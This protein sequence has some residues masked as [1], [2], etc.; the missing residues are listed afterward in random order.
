VRGFKFFQSS[1]RAP[2]PLAGM[3][4][5]IIRSQQG[6][7]ACAV[8]L[9]I[10]TDL[11][12]GG[13]EQRTAAGQIRSTNTCYISGRHDGRRLSNS[14]PDHHDSTRRET[15]NRIDTIN[16]PGLLDAGEGK[17][18]SSSSSSSSLNLY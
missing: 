9:V 2:L 16:Q 17:F 12:A 3:I 7:A 15:R 18:T 10:N 8:Q 4:I 6:R 5:I 13:G 14:R 1:E 11:W